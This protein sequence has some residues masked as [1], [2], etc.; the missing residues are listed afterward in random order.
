MTAE[1]ARDDTKACVLVVDDEEAVRT[2][3]GRILGGAE[4]NVTTAKSAPEAL[5]LLHTKRFDA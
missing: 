4:F 5:G 2:A 3:V 1:P